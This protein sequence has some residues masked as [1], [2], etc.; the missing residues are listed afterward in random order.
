MFGLRQ[1]KQRSDAWFTFPGKKTQ[2]RWVPIETAEW[3]ESIGKT[4]SMPV[5]VVG[6]AIAQQAFREKRVFKMSDVWEKYRYNG[7]RRLSIYVDVPLGE[8]IDT[9]CGSQHRS[10]NY[11]IVSLLKE[12]HN[13]FLEDGTMPTLEILETSERGQQ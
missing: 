7:H 4:K 9:L 12:A 2:I 10:I 8:W 13:R 5:G 11:V 3:M 6:W 1:R